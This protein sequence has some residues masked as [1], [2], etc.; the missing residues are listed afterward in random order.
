M[1]QTAHIYASH[2][3]ARFM[4][5]ELVSCDWN[6]TGRVTVHRIT[7]I[8]RCVRG[9]QTGTMFLVEPPLHNLDRGNPHRDPRGDWIDCAWFFKDGLEV[10]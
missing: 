4:L 2:P 6:C 5:Y 8:Q 7:A 9:S 10:L 1:R 3:S